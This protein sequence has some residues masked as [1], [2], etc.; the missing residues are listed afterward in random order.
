MSPDKKGRIVKS[1]T[2][3]KLVTCRL[4]LIALVFDLVKKYVKLWRPLN[5]TIILFFEDE[6]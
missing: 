4:D 3:F 2:G 5:T 6:K 1:P